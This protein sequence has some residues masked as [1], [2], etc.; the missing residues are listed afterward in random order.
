[1][2]TRLRQR[3]RSGEHTVE[4]L[5]E[6]LRCGDLTRSQ[7]ELAAYCGHEAARVLLGWVAGSNGRIYY[8]HSGCSAGSPDALFSGA[9]TQHFADWLRGLE[10]WPGALL[11]ATKAARRLLYRGTFPAF[12]VWDNSPASKLIEG[13]TSA[14]TQEYLP[15]TSGPIGEQPVRQAICAAL[16]EWALGPGGGL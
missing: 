11:R 13:I 5:A 15:H 3:G 8:T 12:T 2:D 9:G 6:R 4:S 14:A 7:V 10:W 1:M 16:I